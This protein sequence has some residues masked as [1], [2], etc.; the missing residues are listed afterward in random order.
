MNELLAGVLGGL[1]LFIVG[2][3][4]LTENLKTLASARLR[5]AATRWTRNRF[6]AVLW[7]ALAGGITQSM[8]ALTFIVVSILRSGLITTKGA[9]ALILGG[10]VGVTALVIIVT[11][12][13]KVVALYV[14][15]VSGAAMVSERLAR[16]RAL[17]ASLLGAAMIIFGLTLLKEAAAPLADQPWFEDLIA[18]TARSLILAFSVGALLTFLVQSSSAVSVFAISLAT[19]GIISVDQA[20]MI[21]YGTNAGSAAIIHMLSTSLTGRSRQ[22]AM[23]IV[24]YNVLICAVLVP[25]LYVELHLD[26]PLVKALVLSINVEPDQQ[27]ALVYVLMCTFLLPLM[28]A[29]LNPSVRLLERWWPT[30]RADKLSQFK[31][32]HGNATVDIDSSLAL[33]DLEQRRVLSNLSQYFNAIRNEEPTI[34]SLREALRKLLSDIDEFLSDLETSHPIQHVENR[35]ATRNRQKLLQWLENA[36]GTLCE[37]L[38]ELKERDVLTRFRTSICE[39]VDSVLLSLIDAVADDDETSWE[40]TRQ[41]TGDRSD[42]MRRLRVRYLEIEPPLRKVEMINV[43]LVTNSVE[44]AFY[45]FGKIEKEFSPNGQIKEHVPRA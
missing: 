12:D 40:I 28:L 4:L 35:N 8:T 14:L 27:L 37:T 16:Y 41:L 34:A 30:S 2:M 44:E 5:R 22:V 24:G 36:L 19:V 25:L 7:G 15:A 20:I 3:W 9:L 17:A 29:G 11:F 45:L 26:V 31:F 18:G 42:M 13:I 43:L 21:M 1:G 6:T 23:Y 32:I 38:S 33:V 39:S 10:C